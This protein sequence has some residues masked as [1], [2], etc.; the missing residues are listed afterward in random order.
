[1]SNLELIYTIAFSVIAATFVLYWII[2]AIKNGWIK[3]ITQTLNSAMRYAENNITGPSEKKYY[4][5]KQVEAKC[6]EEGIPFFLIKGLISKVIERIV[7][8]HN[9]FDHGD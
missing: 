1:M 8:D 2:M 9:V 7:K 3:K 6:E 5:L 4:V